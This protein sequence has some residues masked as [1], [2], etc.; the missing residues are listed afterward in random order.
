[1]T[2]YVEIDGPLPFSR[3][4]VI[5]VLRHKYY[6]MGKAHCFQKGIH[7]EKTVWGPSKNL[8]NSLLSPETKNGE[9]L[10]YHTRFQ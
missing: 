5:C 8:S 4:V 9:N 10:L 6:S 1:M 7:P 2:A 3:Y